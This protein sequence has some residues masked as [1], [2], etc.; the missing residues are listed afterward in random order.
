MQKKFILLLVLIL[1]AQLLSGC[2][3]GRLMVAENAD[4]QSDCTAIDNEIGLAEQRI[5]Q[6]DETDN[7]VRNIRDAVLGGVSF[8]VPPLVFPPL[9]ILNVALFLNDSMTADLVEKDVLEDRH[10]DFVL[11]AQNMDCGFQKALIPQPATP[12]EDG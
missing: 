2:A 7:T 9:A 6:I 3:A 8:I 5:S 10:N 4:A 1:S 12:N 11:V